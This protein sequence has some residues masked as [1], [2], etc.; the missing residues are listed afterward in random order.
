MAPLQSPYRDDAAA[1]E[2]RY[3]DLVAE[4]HRELRSLEDLAR[5][6][7][8]RIGRIAAGITGCV[9]AV[10]MVGTAIGIALNGIEIAGEL[11]WILLGSWGAMA[12]AYAAGRAFARRRFNAIAMPARSSD[13]W[14]DIARLEMPIRRDM[15]EQI[16]R[17]EQ[18]SV[19]LPLIAIALLAPLSLHACVYGIALA[20]LDDLSAMRN[21]DVW[22]L[23]SL[24]I[25]GH[26]HIV[27]A[28]LCHRFA[29]ACRKLSV[30]E[31]EAQGS[32]IGW[33]AYGWSLLA[34]A[35]PG[36]VL[37]LLPPIISAVTGLLFSPAMF[38][39]M[40]RRIVQERHLLSAA[41]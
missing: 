38:S 9:G 33:R 17:Y 13:P 11:S 40:R 30:E 32:H 36:A 41:L 16:D 12:I 35:I 4:R 25:V 29:K 14:A 18:R 28:W 7:Q 26:A 8:R 39:V 19:A 22:I 27:L 15:S 2:I 5:V 37:Y 31:V 24:C 34:S 21:F 3:G 1:A 20:V 10:L 23:W 6:H